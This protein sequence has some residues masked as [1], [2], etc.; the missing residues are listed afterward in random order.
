[1]VMCEEVDE[2]EDAGPYATTTL[3]VLMCYNTT[4]MN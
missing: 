4:S 1:M 3:C 2:D